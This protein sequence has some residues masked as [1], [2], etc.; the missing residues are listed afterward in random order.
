MISMIFLKWSYSE[1]VILFH[2]APR[3]S[4]KLTKENKRLQSVNADI[5]SELNKVKL[6]V[7]QQL[8]DKDDEACKLHMD[9]EMSEW[10]LLVANS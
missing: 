10:K 1:L 7:E 2:D 5:R 9:L 3:M 8:K 4:V 6:D